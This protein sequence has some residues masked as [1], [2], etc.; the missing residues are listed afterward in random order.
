MTCKKLIEMDNLRNLSDIFRGGDLL[1]FSLTQNVDAII[2]TIT[3][4]NDALYN[5]N[6]YI[7]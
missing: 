6:S 5:I 3:V 1:W 7:E 4:S 2:H